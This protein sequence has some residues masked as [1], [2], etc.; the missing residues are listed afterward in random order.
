MELVSCR[1]KRVPTPTP[2]NSSI[3]PLLKDVAHTLDMQHHLIKFCIEY[4]NTLNPQQVTAVD[5][6]DQPIY[7]LAKLSNGNIRICSVGPSHA[8]N[9]IKNLKEEIL[10]SKF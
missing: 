10:L 8:L 6:L 2:S 9:S 5:C 3:F 4:T 1:K 7:A